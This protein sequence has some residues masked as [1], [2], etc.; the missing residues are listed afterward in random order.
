M[1]S[2]QEAVK[3]LELHA[4]LA[5]LAKEVQK[6]ASIAVPAENIPVGT[7]SRNKIAMKACEG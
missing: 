1:Q 4:V 7:W 2:L 3:N 6:Q 5:I